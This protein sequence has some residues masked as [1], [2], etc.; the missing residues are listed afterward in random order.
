MREELGTVYRIE[1]DLTSC[2]G[3]E[4]CVARLLWLTRQRDARCC[5][6]RTILS[7]YEGQWASV[8]VFGP[9]AAP[10]ALRSLLSTVT[11]PAAILRDRVCRLTGV[12]VP[13]TDDQSPATRR[14]SS[15]GR[16]PRLKVGSGALDE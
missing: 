2:D 16:A 14:T 5:T 12:G 8:G 4:E 13:A 10:S 6:T 3:P 15:G 7:Y 1:R 11:G 9:W